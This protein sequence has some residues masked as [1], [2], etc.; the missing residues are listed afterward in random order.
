MLLTLL[1]LLPCKVLDELSLCFEPGTVT[2]LCGPSGDDNA[3]LDPSCAL[4]CDPSCDPS[5]DP[6]CLAL[7]LYDRRPCCDCKLLSDGR[8]AAA[9]P[10]HA[11]HHMRP[12]TCA[13]SHAPSHVAVDECAR[14]RQC[15]GHSDLPHNGWGIAGSGKST[16]AALLV[17]FYDPARGKVFCRCPLPLHFATALCHCPFQCLSFHCLFAALSWTFH[18]PCH[19]LHRCLKVTMDGVALP[20]LNAAKLRDR[21][22]G[23]IGQEPTLFAGECATAFLSLFFVAFLQCLSAC[24]VPAFVARSLPQHKAHVEHLIASQA[25]SLR[26]FGTAGRT[27]PTPRSAAA[28]RHVG[29]QRPDRLCLCLWLWLCTHIRSQRRPGPPTPSRSSPHCR[30]GTL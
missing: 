13:P 2:A 22:V 29:R 25:R 24:V 28:P 11:P 26:T 30:P 18:G 6:Y 27:P 15:G 3:R 16:V 21:L 19:G 14:Q 20:A 9:T 5:C 8:P 10:S 4:Y 23:Y 7:P 17:R 1:L 12:I